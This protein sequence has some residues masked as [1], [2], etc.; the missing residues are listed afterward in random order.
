LR[1]VSLRNR[2]LWTRQVDAEVAAS[3]RA[4][5][6]QNLQFLRAHSQNLLIRH[7]LGI[8]R[9]VPAHRG[10]GCRMDDVVHTGWKGRIARCVIAV[11][12]ADDHVPNRFGCDLCNRFNEGCRRRR[13]ALSVCD[14]HPV[15][16]HHEHVGG[17][18]LLVSG[19]KVFVGVDVVGDFD[20]AGEVA[21]LEAALYRVG[22]ANH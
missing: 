22:G 18:E 3:V 6:E 13:I 5:E 15:V 8:G 4:P 11:V 20:R 21:V 9:S 10:L 19:V 12:R 7:E 16:S 1:N 17:G 14:E 2:I